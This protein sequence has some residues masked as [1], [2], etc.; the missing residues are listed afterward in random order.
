[1]TPPCGVPASGSHC[2]APSRT[3]CL[4]RRSCVR[5]RVHYTVTRQG[6]SPCCLCA[7]AG[8][9]VQASRLPKLQLER[10]PS[11]RADHH[12][13]PEA[14]TTI[15]ESH[16]LFQGRSS[17]SYRQV[18]KANKMVVSVAEKLSRNAWHPWR[19]K[20]GLMGRL[21]KRPC[22]KLCLPPKLPF[23]IRREYAILYSALV[24]IGE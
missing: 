5:F 7:L 23:D 21:R 18:A 8:A 3:P 24:H 14:C 22:N 16:G 4:R 12:S 20:K 19:L 15:D 13:R 9:L 1:M 2:S 6:L 17:L 11:G 10:T